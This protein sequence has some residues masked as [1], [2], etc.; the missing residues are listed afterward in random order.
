MSKSYFLVLK[1]RMVSQ[2]LKANNLGLLIFMKPRQRGMTHKTQVPKQAP[3]AAKL[4]N[5]HQTLNKS[6]N[7]YSTLILSYLWKNS[8]RKVIFLNYRQCNGVGQLKYRYG[9]FGQFGLQ[10]STCGLVW[11]WIGGGPGGIGHEGWVL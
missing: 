7:L 3:F 4:R 2:I 10:A 8:E 5:E 6:P 11:L 9:T 1:T